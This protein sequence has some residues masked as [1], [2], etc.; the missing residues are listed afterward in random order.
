MYLLLFQDLQALM[1]FPPQAEESEEN[2]VIQSIYP[3]FLFA[4][5]LF[6][7]ATFVV[8]AL[9]PELRNTHGNSNQ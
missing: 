1:C 7:I 2:S 9:L 8:H 4:S 3:Y 5:S 6:L